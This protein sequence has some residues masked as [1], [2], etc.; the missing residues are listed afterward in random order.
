MTLSRREMCGTLLATTAMALT[1]R[2][3]RAARPTKRR[4]GPSKLLVVHLGGGMDDLFSV[5]PKQ[6]TEVKPKIG[7]L[8]T[9]SDLTTHK[10]IRLAPAWKPLAPYVSRM[11]VLLGVQCK[12]VGHA[13]GIAQVIQMRTG[14]VDV[15]EESFLTLAGGAIAAKTG[16]SLHAVNLGVHGGR[17]NGF[18]DEN[19]MTLTALHNLA[20]DPAHYD[21]G[22][23]ALRDALAGKCAVDCDTLR[24]VDQLLVK[25]RGTALPKPPASRVAKTEWPDFFQGQEPFSG[26]EFSWAHYIFAN[27]LAPVVG[28]SPLPFWDTHGNNDVMQAVLNHQLALWLR[29]LLD[30][31]KATPRP[32]GRTLLDETGIVILSELGRFPYRNSYGGK[33]HFPQIS[34]TLIGPGLVADRFGETNAEL[35]GADLSLKTGRPGRGA[36]AITL[37]DIGRTLFEWVGFADHAKHGYTGD[38]L[39]FCFA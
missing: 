23:R 16:V 15:R 34:V 28:C 24:S 30:N 38:V 9:A 19:G 10:N 12:T 1:P 5:D 27:D 11:Q 21:L 32:G 39:D 31:L 26:I 13:T 7:P 3:A 35:L 29:E 37:D 36:R 14:V 8:F 18:H 17:G 20:N 2:W 22:R 6:K 25:M 4:N 33:D